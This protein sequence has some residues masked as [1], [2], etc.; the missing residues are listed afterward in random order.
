M[1]VFQYRAPRFPSDF[2]VDLVVGKST[3]RGRCNNI[4]SAGIQAEFTTPATV[5][6]VGMLTLDHTQDAFKLYARVTYSASNQTGLSF[7]FRTESER[8]QLLHFVESVAGG[9]SG[10]GTLR[11]SGRR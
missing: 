2:P 1:Y 9:R 5:G 3:I 8:A 7:I 6:D 10:Q 11:S 4:N